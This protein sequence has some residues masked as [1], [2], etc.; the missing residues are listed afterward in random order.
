MSIPVDQINLL[1]E[2][3]NDA[4]IGIDTIIVNNLPRNELSNSIYNQFMTKNGIITFETKQTYKRKIYQ[5]IER[6]I[7]NDLSI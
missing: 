7:T 3:L 5:Q 1:I 4:G 2:S 6:F